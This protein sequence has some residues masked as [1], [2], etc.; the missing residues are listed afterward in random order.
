MTEAA[1]KPEPDWAE[2]GR[3]GGHLH[4]RE[5]VEVRSKSGKITRYFKVTKLQDVTNLISL[6][7]SS[8]DIERIRVVAK[9][10]K[11]FRQLRSPMIHGIFQAE[12]GTLKTLFLD[13]LVETLPEKVLTVHSLTYPAFVGTIDKNTRKVV[14]PFGWR[15]D[16]MIAGIDEFKMQSDLVEVMLQL[17][18]GH[19]YVR[20]QGIAVYADD[21][22]ENETKSSHLFVREGTMSLKTRT[23]FLIFTMYPVGQ[24]VRNSLATKALVSRSLLIPFDIDEETVDKIQD[25]EIPF[26]YKLWKP[27]S[28]V[29]ISLE[30]YKV[31][32]HIAKETGV[33]KRFRLTDA[34]LRAFAVMGE[35]NEEVYDLICKLKVPKIAWTKEATPN[36]GEDEDDSGEEV[37]G[38]PKN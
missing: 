35:H 14:N 19:E 17:A 6:C 29:D 23:V 20:S 9:D 7:A 16:G 27:K 21:N 22:R 3:E 13:R 24:L 37:E 5:S 38:S 30:D 33:K 1:K 2:Y 31:I 34:L 12:I 4:N 15:A 18:E 11:V 10:G 26:E 8:I 32:D 36:E 25:F 28:V